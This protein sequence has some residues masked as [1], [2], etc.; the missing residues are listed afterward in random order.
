M[1]T[2]VVRGQDDGCQIVEGRDGTVLPGTPDGATDEA[3]ECAARLPIG[4]ALAAPPG[5]IGLCVWITPSLGEGDPLQDGVERPI[6][7]AVAPM[8]HD[9]TRGGFQRRGTAMAGQTGIGRKALVRTELPGQQTGGQW[10]DP[11]Q[12]VERLPPGGSRPAPPSGHPTGRSCP[13]RARHAAHQ[14]SAG[15]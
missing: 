7:A 10:S 2:G 6:P 5:E 13:V 4:L 9:L 3:L 11:V 15:D 12:V 8:A 1:S 14:P